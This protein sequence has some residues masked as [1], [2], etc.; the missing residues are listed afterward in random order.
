MSDVAGVSTDIRP[1]ANELHKAA[2]RFRHIEMLLLL[3]SLVLVG[4]IAG[5]GAYQ[6]H[7][8][9]S[10]LQEIESNQRLIEEAQREIANNIRCQAEFFASRDATALQVERQHPDPRE[11][12]SVCFREPPPPTPNP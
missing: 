1:I 9:R 11:V 10:I 7:Q 6:T 8:L 3:V 2:S 12:L 4:L 5:F